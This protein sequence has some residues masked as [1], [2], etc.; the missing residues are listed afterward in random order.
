MS[1]I[2]MD[3]NLERLTFLRKIVGFARAGV[4]PQP[5]LIQRCSEIVQKMDE[6]GERL[7]VAQDQ[8]EATRKVVA[9]MQSGVLPSMA[10]CRESLAEINEKWLPLRNQARQEVAAS[11][12]N[13]ILTHEQ[14]SPTSERAHDRARGT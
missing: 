3:E 1:Q 4:F 5:A 2:K 9:H 10:A 7:G 6:K 13:E 8:I 11:S 14:D 12:A